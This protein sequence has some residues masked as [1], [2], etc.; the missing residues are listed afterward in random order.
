MNAFEAAEKNGRAD[1]LKRELDNLFN[2]HNQ[3]R[4][5]D[6]TSIPATYLRVTVCALSETA[7]SSRS[8]DCGFGQRTGNGR[9]RRMRRTQGKNSGGSIIAGSQDAGYRQRVDDFCFSLSSRRITT[10][11]ATSSSG[12]SRRCPPIR[13]PACSAS[14]RN[15]WKIRSLART[16]TSRSSPS[17][18]PTPASGLT[19]SPARSRTTAAL[20]WSASSACSRTSSRE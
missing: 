8:G 6:A 19:A 13:S 20:A 5:A 1:D 16:W 12:G 7:A 10:T 11:R 17:T 9:R 15:A 18:R 4:D 14:R 3:S 2:S